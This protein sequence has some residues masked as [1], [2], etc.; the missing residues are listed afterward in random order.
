MPRVVDAVVREVRPERRHQVVVVADVPSESPSTYSAGADAPAPPWAVSATKAKRRRRRRPPPQIVVLPQG[1]E[2][3]FTQ[4]F[5]ATGGARAKRTG[6]ASCVF[7][8]E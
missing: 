5:Q 6:T 2:A 3:I 4:G 7:Y 8:A 1:G